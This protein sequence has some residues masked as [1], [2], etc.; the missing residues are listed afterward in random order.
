MFCETGPDRRPDRASN[1]ATSLPASQ[2]RFVSLLA[3]P[4][5]ASMELFDSS[6]ELSRI[7]EDEE[8]KDI[9]SNIGR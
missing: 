6:S 1:P 7:E 2:P 5:H 9:I 4:P 3:P 8:V